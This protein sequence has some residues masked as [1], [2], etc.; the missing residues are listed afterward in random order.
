MRSVFSHRFTVP[1]SAI[2]LNGHVNNIE[3]LR[4]MQD[5]A[6]AHSAFCGWD[7]E[8]YI[9]TQSSWVVRSHHIDYLRPAYAGDALTLIT[10]IAGFSG[11]TSPR[12]Y[13]LRRDTDDQILA[14][15]ETLWVYVD[16]RSGRPAEIP[17]SFRECFDVITDETLALAI[18]RGRPVPA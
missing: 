10:W 13:V 17:E 9:E 3:Y 2:D 7:I 11:Q 8:R 12:R 16:G 6:T 15:A 1:K 14:R 5:V 18:A 4:W